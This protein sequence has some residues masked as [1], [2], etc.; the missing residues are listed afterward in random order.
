MGIEQESGGG[1]GDE[2]QGTGNGAAWDA[3]ESRSGPLRDKS[4]RRCERL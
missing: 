4:V 2:G 1:K 3:E